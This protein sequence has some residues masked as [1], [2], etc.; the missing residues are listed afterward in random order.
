MPELDNLDPTMGQPELDQPDLGGAPAA[1]HQPLEPNDDQEGKMAKA[2]LYK[3]ATYSHK[4]FKQLNDEDKLESWVQA[5]ITK[6]ADYMAS[7]YHYLEYEMKFSEYGHH[8]DNSDTL[9]EG[10]KMKI[11]ELLSEAKSKVKELKKTQ[12]EK[13]KGKK[14]EEGILSGGDRPCTECGGTGMVYE[15]PKAIPDHVKGKV[16]KYNTMVKATKAA[17]KRMDANHNGIPDEDEVDENLV[18]VPNPAGQRDPISTTKESSDNSPFNWKSKSKD[19]ENGDY[20]KKSSTGGTTKKKGNVTTHTHNPDRFNDEP[21]D[22]K[23]DRTKSHAKAR[24][25]SDKAGDREMDKAQEKDSRAWGKANPGKQTIMKGGVKTTNECSPG[26][27]CPKCKA[28]QVADKKKGAV[29]EAAKWRDPKHKDKLYTQE[30]RDPDD[31]YQSDDDY[32]NP[33]PDDYPGAKNLKG[34]SEYRHNDPLR[35]GYGR[36][37]VGSL[38]THG[39]RKGMPSRDHITSLKGSIKDAHGKHPHPNLP[40]AAPRGQKSQDSVIKIHQISKSKSPGANLTQGAEDALEKGNHKKIDQIHQYAT[41]TTP[42][43]RAKKVSEAKPSAGLSAAKKSAVVKDAKAGKDIGKPGKSF[44]KVAKSAGGGE[45]GEKI[46]AAAMW[47]NIK[48]TTAYIAEKKA[49]TKNLPGKQEKIDVAEPK[50]KI[51]GKDMAALRAKKDTV[52]ESTEFTRMQEQIARLNRTEKPML[53]ESREI[54]QLKA[55]TNLFKG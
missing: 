36:Y 25:S 37:G 29:K 8:L 51:D 23:N 2:D 34:G 40:E 47:K 24:S 9:S 50:G 19:D 38:N 49:A 33:K 3:L 13:V 52:K 21:Y 48:E 4:L 15:E 27:D 7:V 55:L 28:K 10:Q 30:P 54:D 26:C 6:A 12:A 11:K 53:S 31:Y 17:H 46:A 16:A 39:K 41:T 1:D 42:T 43:G 18:V 45:K 22:A 14:V 35:A 44:D 20:E 5:K 32:Y